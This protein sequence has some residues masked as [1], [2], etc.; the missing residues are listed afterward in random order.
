MD[1]VENTL[2]ILF[3]TLLHKS[4]YIIELKAINTFMVSFKEHLNLVTESRADYK[5]RIQRGKA[6]EER[7]LNALNNNNKF[8]YTIR[9]ASREQDMYQGIDALIDSDKDGNKLNNT[10][11]VQIKERRSG[12]D[13]LLEVI[14]PWRGDPTEM[15]GRDMKNTPGLYF[16]I[17]SNKVL[18]IIKGDDVKRAVSESMQESTEQYNPES[19]NNTYDTKNGQVKIVTDPSSQTNYSTGKVDK[20]NIF[21][22]PNALDVVMAIPLNF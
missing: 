22:N 12:N 2:F 7:I 11:T 14:K 17:D 10:W 1:W 18:R 6:T 15:T 20:V 21:L 8:P 13:I 16:M 5:E 19:R 9:P 4:I 3:I